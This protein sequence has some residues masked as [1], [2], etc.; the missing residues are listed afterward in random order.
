MIADSVAVLL[1][2]PSAASTGTCTG[3]DQLAIT[4]A[5]GGGKVGGVL[6]F[7]AG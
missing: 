2:F 5:G 1:C 7:I 4:A 6:G 3:G